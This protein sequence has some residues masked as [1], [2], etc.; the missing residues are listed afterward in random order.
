[1]F[2]SD[3]LISSRAGIMEIKDMMQPHGSG[4]MEEKHCYGPI[5]RDY[6]QTD[7]ANF[8]LFILPYLIVSDLNHKEILYENSLISQPPPNTCF[9][10]G[11]PC[12]IKLNFILDSS[13]PC[14][15]WLCCHTHVHHTC[16]MLPFHSATT[17]WLHHV[18]NIHY[19]YP[20]QY[21]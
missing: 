11:K 15:A 9:P 8:S 21:Q 14:S 7:L 18:I 6:I 4:R 17:M 10:H 20:R 12:S 5:T 1:M 2:V 13:F 16:S 19:A 3:L